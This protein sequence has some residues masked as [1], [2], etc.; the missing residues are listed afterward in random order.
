VLMVVS[1]VVLMITL[2]A[3]MLED[4]HILIRQ[5]AN[6]RV[7][8][9]SRHYAQGL[10]AWAMRVLQ[11]D[12]DRFLDH[13]DEK[14]ATF[15]RPQEEVSED[16]PDQGFSLNSTRQQEEEEEATID[17]GIDTL[18]VTIDDLQGR[19]NLNNLV[20]STEDGSQPQPDQ[21]QIFLNL[22]QILEIGEFQEDRTAMYS[23]LVDW[24]DRDQDLNGAGNGAE[25]NDYQIRSTPY[26][27]SDQPLGNVGELRYVKGF[28]K[29]VIRKLRPF[30]TVLPIQRASLNLNTVSP[31]VLASLA[32]GPVADIAQVAGFLG[33]KE[34][35]GFLGFQ[36]GDIQAAESAI[37]GV[38]P[39]NNAITGM[40]QVNS[41]FFQINAKVELGDFKVCTRTIVLRNAADTE[42]LQPISVLSREQD[43]ICREEAADAERGD[44]ELGDNEDLS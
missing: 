3:L 4:Q 21:R 23:S 15:G 24:M 41:Q 10:N 28:N 11:E 6:Q 17:F 25:S 39:G 36:G 40:L 26:F 5:T 44:Q 16:D 12:A 31:E 8:E 7:A 35:P 2:L 19:Y 27:A 29:E 1:V 38:S 34:Q 30:V 22:L 33:R 20:I 37:N 13:E 14:W 9:Q 43:T 32:G 18:E 42:T